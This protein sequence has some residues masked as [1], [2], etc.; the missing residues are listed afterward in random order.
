MQDLNDMVIFARVVQAGGFTAAAEVL[1]LPKSNVSRRVARLE[2][3]L[4]VRLLERTTRKIHVTE[5]GEIYFHHCLR[6]IEESEHADLSVQSMVAEPRGILRVS[7]SVTTGQQL[8][9]PLLPSFMALFPNIELQLELTNRRIDLIEEGLDVAI[10]V[11]LL[12]DS[13]LVSRKL[14]VSQHHLYACQT[15]L[16]QQAILTKPEQ[17][18][19]HHL[20]LMSD[21]T[22]SKKGAKHIVVLNNNEQTQHIS[23]QPVCTA[24]DFH[25]LHQFTK[26]GMGIAVLPHYMCHDPD[27]KLIRVLPEWT[28]PSLD[29]HAIYPSHRGA[30]PK[31]RVFL[32]FMKKAFANRLE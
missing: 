5:I 23:V 28:C 2:S 26:Q 24:N 8:L 7:A 29:F 20:L 6:I 10:R 30:T 18:C 13:R 15:Y 31:L 3:D 9:A 17:L 25:S 32:D 21:Q 14:G 1:A 12:E 19:S 22:G 11:G 4:G 27:D 16:D